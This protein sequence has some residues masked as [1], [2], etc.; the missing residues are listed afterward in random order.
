MHDGVADDQDRHAAAID[1]AVG[2]LGLAVRFDIE[3]FMGDAPFVQVAA[4]AWES[5]RARVLV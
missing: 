1:L 2:A 3:I 5:Q 4:Q